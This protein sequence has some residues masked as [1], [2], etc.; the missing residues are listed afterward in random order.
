MMPPAAERMGPPPEDY[1]KAYEIPVGNSPVK[2]P[3]K[4]KI[5]IVGFLDLQ[6]PFSARFQPVIDQVL[7]DY[8]DTVNYR[9]KHFPLGF[10][11]QAKPAAKAVLAA[12]EQGKYWE[13][14]AAI[15][16]DNRDLNAEKLK[17]LAKD[18]KLNIKKYEEDLKNND[19]QW[20]KQIAEEFALGEKIDVRGTPTYYLQGKKT[21]A[22]TP[23]DFK[24]TIDAI[25]NQK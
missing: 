6:C 19:A 13:M 2:G 25:L 24:K 3:D 22:R 5:T 21:R 14:L 4:A 23:E 16:K 12:G 11:Q 20:E 8:P 1:T 10:H 9:I 7:A 18:L 17:A 15:L